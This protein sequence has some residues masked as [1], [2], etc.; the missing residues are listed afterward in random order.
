MRFYY[1]PSLTSLTVPENPC[2]HWRSSVLL[3]RSDQFRNAGQSN[4]YRLRCVL[5]LRESDQPDNSEQRHRYSG[6]GAFSACAGLTNVTI[7]AGVSNIVDFEFADCSA[8]SSISIPSNVTSIGYESFAGCT[9]LTKIL[10]SSGLTSIGGAAFAGCGGLTSIAIPNGVSNIGNDAFLACANLSSVSFPN[11][12]TSLGDEA[13]EDCY[14]LNGIYFGGNAPQV[15]RDVF[16]GD[17]NAV[18]Y[19]L[20]GTT[21]WAST[22]AGSATALWLPSLQTGVTTRSNQFGFN[23]HWA[24]G[25]TVVVE[26]A[27]NLFNPDWQALQTNMLTTDSTYFSDTNWTAYPSRFYRIRSP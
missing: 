6:G 25:Q 11:S 17:G 18:V 16:D 13:F 9:S 5:S 20:P 3:L 7:G 2:Q 15:G 10:F 12:I 19:Y 26:V 27:T 8:L 14:S 23:I 1:C 24:S 22:F 4:K 21:G